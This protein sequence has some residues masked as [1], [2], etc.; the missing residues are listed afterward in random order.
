MPGIFE[1]AELRES[2]VAAFLCGV[3]IGF[4]F[5][6]V[7]ISVYFFWL[8]PAGVSARVGASISVEERSK[9]VADET[10]ESVSPRAGSASSAIEMSDFV[11]NVNRDRCDEHVGATEDFESSHLF[12]PRVSCLAILLLFQSVSSTILEGF[13]SLFNSHTLIV[14]FLTTIVGLGGNVSGQSMVLVVREIAL[15]RETDWKR[16]LWVGLWICAVVV[17][18]IFLRVC[19]SRREVD[20]VTILTV[21][22]SSAV[23][24][25][26]GAA[27]GSFVPLVLR[28]LRIDPA[29]AAPLLQVTMDIVGVSVVC[30]VAQLLV[31][32][33]DVH[34]RPAQSLAWMFQP[35]VA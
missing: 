29:H 3:S 28:R 15:G 18:V 13:S 12:W 11:A 10:S 7:F 34:V 8:T 31:G 19:F 27:H 20:V 17:P 35:L 16:Q 23:V 1:S 6:F 24:V 26:L 14:S 4:A 22:L 30:C 21:T 5:C 33:G 2:F 9:L 32:I 25:V